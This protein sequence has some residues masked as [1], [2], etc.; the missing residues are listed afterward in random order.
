VLL[1]GDGLTYADLASYVEEHVGHLSEVALE[2][3]QHPAVITLTPGALL[4]SN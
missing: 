1:G 4:R 3:P 2:A